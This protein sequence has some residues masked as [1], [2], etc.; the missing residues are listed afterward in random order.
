MTT[1]TAKAT[2]PSA[3]DSE[4]GKPP[5]CLLSQAVEMRKEW[6]DNYAKE[7]R[8]SHANAV[9]RYI[10]L[11]NRNEHPREGDARDLAQTMFDMEIDAD[12]VAR[13]VE[14]IKRARRFERLHDDKDAA[15]ERYTIAASDLRALIKCC[16]Q[17]VKDAEQKRGNAQGYNFQCTCANQNLVHLRRQR[18]LLFTEGSTLRVRLLEPIA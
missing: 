15:S 8:D 6:D 17:K 16:E 18:P 13:D 10:E 7:G 14:I 11:V 5:Q 12:M 3:A 4:S 2:K 9:A 1:A